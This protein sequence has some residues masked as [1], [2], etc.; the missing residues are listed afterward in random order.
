MPAA[1][2][3]LDHGTTTPVAPEAA[4]AMA[5]A[6]REGTGS[7][8]SPHSAGLASREIVD[9]A[10]TQVAT[11]V[12]AA[13][14]EIVFT[15]SET[16]AANLALF[17]ALRASGKQ[18]SH[19]VI[20][21][22]EH[23]SV[24]HIA[25]ELERRHGVE[26]TWIP[27]DAEGRISPES[28]A[29]AL[30]PETVLAVVQHAS[31]EIGTVQPV[32][33][34]AAAV[35]ARGALLFCD[36]SGSAGWTP[37]DVHASGIDLLS[38]APH[39]FFGPKGTGALFV[40]RGLRIEPGIVGGRQEHDLRAGIEN[41]PGIAG[42]GAA[43][44]LAR[45][46]LAARAETCRA[47]IGALERLLLPAIPQARRNGPA[48]GER[49]PHL[50]S[51]GI[52]HIESEALILLLDLQGIQIGGLTGCVT[53]DHPLVPPVLRAIGLP[54]PLARGTVT[55]GV[56]PSVSEGD[57]ARAAAA[58]ARCVEKIRGMSQS[59]KEAQAGA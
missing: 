36:G 43:A 31:P 14:E 8:S 22:T 1:P 44:D 52:G 26:L 5:R 28:V 7:P 54:E 46:S 16:E 41:V 39:R 17:G 11:L 51:L 13:P 29:A 18:G 25:L 21:A 50:L 23:P 55:L 56:D 12:G 10:R 57:L 3:Y 24:C 47:R 34:I 45:R 38:L 48:A 37:L 35:H 58:V 59:W 53:K 30:R 20:A 2:L 33:E 49:L 4:E 15:G 9:I 27:S 42:A 19:I 6:L 32:A 40:R